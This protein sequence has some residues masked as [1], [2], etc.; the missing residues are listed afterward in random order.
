MIS[1]GGVGVNTQFVNSKK[2]GR[3]N[4]ESFIIRCC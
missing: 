3:D 1:E 2:G 4:K